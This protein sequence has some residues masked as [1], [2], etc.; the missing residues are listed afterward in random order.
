MK[1]PAFQRI[2]RAL[3][4]GVA[5][6]V[7][8]SVVACK[9]AAAPVAAAPKK[10]ATNTVV[11]T[12]AAAKTNS[13]EYVSVF[14]D[15]LPA[16]KAKD[17][18]Y[19]NST[20]R[21]KLVV[22]HFQTNGVVPPPEPQ[23]ILKGTSKGKFAIINNAELELGEEHGVRV[24]GGGRVAVKVLEIGDDYVFVSIRGEPGKKKL[25]LETKRSHESH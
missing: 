7:S 9:P 21:F 2:S 4:M 17:P 13:D 19:P 3:L 14:S 20:R 25:L 10:P 5:V 12:T 18:F 16:E 1:S 22:P 23:L 8:L 24:A 11:S 15:I 6:A